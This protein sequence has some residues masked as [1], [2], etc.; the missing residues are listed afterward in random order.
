M[1]V[2][3]TLTKQKE[4]FAPIHDKNVGFYVCGVTV[5]DECHLGHARAYVCFDVIRRYLE[6]KGYKVKFIKNFTDIDDKIINR[7]LEIKK[8]NPEKEL[9][10][11]VIELTEKYIADYYSVMDAL[12]IK[13]ADIYPKATE[14]IQEMI[15]MIQDLIDKGF[16]YIV[17][18][19]VYFEVAKFKD[20][21]KLS[22]KNLDD[23]QSGQ[24]VE[25]DDRKK[26]P[27]DFALWKSVKPDEPSWESPWGNG[28]P[29][30]HIEC[31]AMSAKYLDLPFDIHGGGCDLVFPH[32][33]NEIAQ[34]ECA[35]GKK[36]AKYWMHNGFLNINK[37]KMSKSL[38]NFFTLNE[39][40]K[41]YK[42]EIVRFFLLS[43]H[44]RTPIDFSEERL[45]EAQCQMDR[46]YMM[47]K[48]IDV[49]FTAQGIKKE[50]VDSVYD[51]YEDM[52]SLKEKFIN[53]MDDDFNTA[54]AIG[55]LFE[56]INIANNILVKKKLEKDDINK[57]SAL[58]KLFKE[59]ADILNI[60]QYPRWIVTLESKLSGDLQKEVKDLL[61]QRENARK[62]K[63]WD[64]ADKIRNDL[65]ARNIEIE[66]TAN[67]PV[68]S[69]DYI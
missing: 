41:K 16:A 63:K 2:Y 53:S 48:N 24:R 58:K 49:K 23:L 45:K 69:G 60:F 34:S 14:H 10:D 13:R 5:Y 22:G 65:I 8:H 17:D 47:L 46:A 52:V 59:L 31:S 20:Y 29:G 15:K 66:D 19:D 35:S 7:A 32:H 57:I 33:E 43:S 4:E 30:W 36:F 18:G 56:L 67:G 55:C 21:G 64:A 68:A 25:V 38:G 1:R 12:G 26:S 61:L 39:I 62:E 54:A 11:C 28:R 9:K 6:F 27:L 50:D 42:P 40:F 51:S 44:Y 37:E 3:N